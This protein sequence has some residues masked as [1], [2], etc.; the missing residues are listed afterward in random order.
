VQRHRRE[1]P[2]SA[3]SSGSNPELGTPLAHPK[4]SLEMDDGI[5][6]GSG[7]H[8]LSEEVLQRELSN[9]AS[10]SSF[11]SR[12]FLSSIVFSFLASLMSMQP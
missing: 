11:L 7:R 3:S 1:A 8:H 5:S 6:L 4:G 12:A 10:A 9:M 2:D